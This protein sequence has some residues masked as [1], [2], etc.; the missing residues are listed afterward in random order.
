M[1]TK[2]SAI[3][4]RSLRLTMLG[5]PMVAL[6]GDPVVF[7][8]RKATAMLACLALD[9]P[10]VARSTLAGLLWPEYDADHARGALRRTL[11]TLRTALGGRFVTAVGD[12]IRLD[13]EGVEV[14]V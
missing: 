5:P 6:D 2:R 14:A 7:D 4:R 3:G 9:G 11:S 8:T 10:A 13:E 1:A 12:L